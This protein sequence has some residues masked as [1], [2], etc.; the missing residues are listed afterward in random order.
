MARNELLSRSFM[1]LSFATA[2]LLIA[3]QWQT[4]APALSFRLFPDSQSQTRLLAAHANV[5][6][7]A[8]RTVRLVIDL[9]DRE[10]SVYKQDKLQV[11][12]PVAV[13]QA[14]WET[15]TGTFKVTDMERDPKWQHPIT[16]A[17]VPPGEDNPLGSRWIGFWSDDMGQV[18]FHGTNQEDGIGQAIS[19]G[20]VRMFNEDIEAMYAQVAVG[21]TVIVKP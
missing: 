12:Y 2:G 21:T 20:C 16:Q 3:A 14:G 11:T 8:A 7:A 13:G 18:G 17:V 10:V 19:H 1:F 15:P 9:S 5:S 4:G 6:T